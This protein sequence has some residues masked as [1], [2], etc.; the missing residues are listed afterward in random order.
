M[1]EYVSSSFPDVAKARAVHRL[2]VCCVFRTKATEK[3]CKAM[4]LDTSRSSVSLCV[5]FKIKLWAAA[6]SETFNPCQKFCDSHVELLNSIRGHSLPFQKLSKDQEAL[7]GWRVTPL[8]RKHEI[9]PRILQQCLCHMLNFTTWE[10]LSCCQI[11][12]PP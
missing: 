1:S 8:S 4:W 9:S 2:G 10:C 5:Q 12:L 7:G 3:S 6:P 11:R